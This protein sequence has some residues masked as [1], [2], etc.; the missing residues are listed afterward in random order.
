MK[1]LFPLGVVVINSKITR[2][3]YDG[4]YQ[5]YNGPTGSA[6]MFYTSYNYFKDVKFLDA[7]K[8][9]TELIWFKR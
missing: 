5:T 9:C 2:K 8:H 1:Q 4:A 3:K 7:A 6:A